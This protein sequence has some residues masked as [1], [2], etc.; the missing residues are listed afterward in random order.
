[1]RVS[2]P[3]YIPEIHCFGQLEE[4]LADAA[5]SGRVTTLTY[6]DGFVES[7]PDLR[8]GLVRGFKL[9]E[10]QVGVQP[11]RFRFQGWSVI[12]ILTFGIIS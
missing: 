10:H 1:L 2:S 5:I 8:D 12:V 6:L 4:G 9:R 11:W 3:G 7:L